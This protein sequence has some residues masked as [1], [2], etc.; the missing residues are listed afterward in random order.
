[1]RLLLERL[2]GYSLSAGLATSKGL[3]M[4]TK[5]EHAYISTTPGVCGGEPIIKGTRIAVR[6][7]AGWYKMGRTPDEILELYP[8]LNLAKIYDALSYYHDHQ[9]EIDKLIEENSEEHL[10]KAFNL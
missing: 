6:M 3:A 4:K 7:I 8:H 5:T 2:W 1:M 10:R 9:K